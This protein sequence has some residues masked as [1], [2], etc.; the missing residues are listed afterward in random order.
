MTITQ[1]DREAAAKIEKFAFAL[2][3]EQGVEAVTA[4]TLKG[5]RD[6]AIYVQTFAAHREATELAIVEMLRVRVGEIKHGRFT[7]AGLRMAIT[8]IENGEHHA[9]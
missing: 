3:G 8:A 9:D 2:A 5:G 1:A 4:L 7:K 6:D